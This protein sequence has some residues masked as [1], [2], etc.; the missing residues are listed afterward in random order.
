MEEESNDSDDDVDDGKKR[1]RGGGNTHTHT[2]L[3]NS[4]PTAITEPRGGPW[5]FTPETTNLQSGNH[6]PS[7]DY[8]Q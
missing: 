6:P 5:P 1:G 3:L 2:Q 4:R 7:F 8:A